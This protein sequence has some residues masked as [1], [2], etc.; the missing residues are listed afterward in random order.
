M[1]TYKYN[2]QSINGV[3]YGLLESTKTP[4]K[5]R[6][7]VF[8]DDNDLN[9][10]IALHKG[11]IHDSVIVMPFNT[12][13]KT[14]GNYPIATYIYRNQNLRYMYECEILNNSQF[15]ETT[16]AFRH[17]YPENLTEVTG[18]TGIIKTGCENTMLRF[19]PYSTSGPH[20][21]YSLSLASKVILS[22][23]IDL[24]NTETFTNTIVRCYTERNIIL[25]IGPDK[26]TLEQWHFILDKKPLLVSL[27]PQKV[28]NDPKSCE[29]AIKNDIKNSLYFNKELTVIQ[30]MIASV[31][32]VYAVTNL[33]NI[34][35]DVN[36]KAIK[37]SRDTVL[38]LAIV[39]HEYAKQVVKY[40]IMNY[41]HVKNAL[42]PE[43]DKY[44]ARYLK[45]YIVVN[46][47]NSVEFPIKDFD[48]LIVS[49]VINELIDEGFIKF[50]D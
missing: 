2:E 9:N 12:L 24:W 45:K 33:V 18:Q 29:I 13:K 38:H 8:S 19:S 22:D 37:Q 27:I 10:G 11:V 30:M 50:V 44:V 41:C 46:H 5:E 14:L 48:D 6:Y 25:K 1:S 16:L 40:W 36:M 42:K 34:D 28:K 47:K 17:I 21:Q 49:K 20:N 15:E 39:K 4:R 7:I 3:K 31:N 23:K 35:D 32:G 26:I 43:D